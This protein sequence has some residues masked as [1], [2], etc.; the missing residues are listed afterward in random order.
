VV[1]I[2][3]EKGLPFL[4]KEALNPNLPVVAIEILDVEPE[5]WPDVLREPFA[6]VIKNPLDWA[7]KVND[8]YKPD[9]LCLRLQGIHP[10]GKNL[11][12]DSTLKLVD[13]IRKKIALPLV[14]L[15]CG[16]DTKDNE[17]LVKV[18]E[19]LKGERCLFGDVVQDNYKTLTLAA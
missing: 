18:A 15:G 10:D 11:S 5:D 14:I 2:G 19:L 12:V 7:Q 9:L 3:G 16:D 1:K 13:S 4:N 17:V 8:V 6:D